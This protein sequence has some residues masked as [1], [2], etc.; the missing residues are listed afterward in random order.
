MDKEISGFEDLNVAEKA[1]SPYLIIVPGGIIGPM[2]WQRSQ[3][4]GEQPRRRC[5][6]TQAQVWGISLVRRRGKSL[7]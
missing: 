6:L 1:L 5:G 3:V 4:W 7:D 2:C